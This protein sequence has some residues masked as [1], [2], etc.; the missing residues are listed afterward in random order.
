MKKYLTIHSGSS[1]R[2]SFIFS[3]FLR[4]VSVFLILLLASSCFYNY[5]D[6]TEISGYYLF[7]VSIREN[8]G[9]INSM[10]L[11]DILIYVTSDGNK[12]SPYFTSSDR[13]TAQIH[14]YDPEFKS[15]KKQVKITALDPM[16]V[17]DAG[18]SE[19]LTVDSDQDRYQYYNKDFIISLKRIDDSQNY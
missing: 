13:G 11:S 3:I 19:I 10:G 16:G 6:E 5:Y 2:N 8:Q 4:N 15:G 14:L 17:Y 1:C 12:I 18:H 7:N 9:Q